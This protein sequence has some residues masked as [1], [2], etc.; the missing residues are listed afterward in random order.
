MPRLQNT[1]HMWRRHRATLSNHRTVPTQ[2]SKEHIKFGANWSKIGQDIP[3]C[4]L[5]KMADATFLNLQ[6]VPFWTPSDTCI[7]HIWGRA[8][9]IHSS[10][11]STSVPNLLQI[12][13]ELAE[14]RRFF[15]FSKMAAAAISSLQKVLFYTPVYPCIDYISQYTK[16]GANWSII[17]QDMQFCVFSKMSVAAILNF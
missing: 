15:V 6:K 10:S 9:Q 2:A 4:V 7:V 11:S 14:I 5:S 16:F 1:R 8:L 12:G 13:P 3:F 17:G